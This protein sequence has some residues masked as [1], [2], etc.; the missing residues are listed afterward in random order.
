[1]MK[2]GIS[3]IATNNITEASGGELQR[4]SIVEHS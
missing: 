2:T 3:Q 1:M 4:V